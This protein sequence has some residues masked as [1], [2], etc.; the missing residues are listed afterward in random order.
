MQLQPII[1]S[2]HNPL[3]KEMLRLHLASERHSQRRF[4]IEGPHLVEEAIAVMWPLEFLF[5]EETWGDENQAW[6]QRIAMAPLPSPSIL[7]P[8]SRDIMRRLSTTASSCPIIGIAKERSQQSDDSSSLSL[9]IAVESLQ[10]PGNLGALIRVTAAAGIDSVYMGAHS[11]AATNPKVLR[12]AAGQWFRSPPVTVDLPSF[13]EYQSS[14][15]VQILAAS[16]EGRSYW[17]ID[18]TRPTIFLLGNE[19]N[20]LSPGVRAL[21]S[22]TISIPM[23]DRVESLNVA[24]A[25]ALLVYEARRQRRT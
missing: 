23:A 17:D 20:G 12:S 18:L 3:F 9:A 13:L 15:S 21:A 6:L 25:G 1:T 8:V 14:L 2:Q 7:Q 24:V 22:G 11:V 4:L 5:F 10:D 16:A 19:G